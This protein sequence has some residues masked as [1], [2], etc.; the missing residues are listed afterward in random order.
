MK[1]ASE[2]ACK[3]ENGEVMHV[4]SVMIFILLLLGKYYP[5]HKHKKTTNT[6]LTK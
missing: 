1:I 2:T 3:N 4:M 6:A 5:D